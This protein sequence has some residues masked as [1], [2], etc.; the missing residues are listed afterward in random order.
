[1]NKE[2]VLHLH[3]RILLRRQK[4]ATMK[5][6]GKWLKLAKLILGELT[7]TQEDKQDI[8]LLLCEYC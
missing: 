2:N 1:M 5:F 4:Y 6:E 7:R 8:H 3:Y